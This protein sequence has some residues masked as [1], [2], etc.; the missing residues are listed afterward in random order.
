MKYGYLPGIRQVVYEAKFDLIV[1]D[2]IDFEYI[3]G[4]LKNIF[5]LKEEL[6]N[7]KYDEKKEVDL[8]L[9]ERMILL[10]N[11]IQSSSGIPS[12]DLGRIISH[13][14]V[15]LKDN[16]YHLIFSVYIPRLTH[17]NIE[18][19]L[20]I[21]QMSSKIFQFMFLK[22]IKSLYS[23]LD[24]VSK[25]IVLRFR[26]IYKQ[27][28]TM[29]PLL[30]QA[31][32]EDIPF[33]RIT[34][35]V[36]QLGLGSKSKL[37][38]RSMHD[39][40]SS[41]GTRISAN[42]LLT[43]DAF[44]QAGFP[45]LTA[46]YI[47]DKEDLIKKAEKLKW[48]VVVKPIDCGRSEGVTVDIRN[49]KLLL[50]AYSY[51]KKFS[52][53][54]MIEKYT[55][56]DV[57]RIGLI[58]N[59]LFLVSRRLPKGIVGDSSKKIKELI[60]EANEIENKKAPW[61]RFKPFPNDEEALRCIKKQGYTFD[62]IIKKDEFVF[63]REIPSNVHG[64]NAEDWTDKIHPANI[65]LAKQISKFLRLDSIGI[66]MISSSIDK[67][68]YEN[69]AK[70]LEV[71]ATPALGNSA[72]PWGNRRLKEFLSNC[73]PLGTRIPVNVYVGG[74]KALSKAMNKLK[75]LNQNGKSAYLVNHHSIYNLDGK[76]V[77]LCVENFFHRCQSLFMNINVEYLIVVIQTDE[78]LEIG[79]PFDKIS[80]L[81]IVDDNLISCK[82][83]KK[84]TKKRIKELKNI[85]SYF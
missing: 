7:L 2:N 47:K 31:F 38:F 25:S 8:S 82:T 55:K 21:Y 63:L 65:E 15:L 79:F 78:F 19:R 70:I 32:H 76:E 74:K 71:N 48:P 36:F 57:Y 17:V 73:F 6:V 54:I 72:I 50:A 49:E 80:E 20:N 40:D 43:Y 64:G 1:V 9:I 68:W 39:S 27:A 5:C 59:D 60:N 44:K 13:Q 62:S 28:D 85:L 3:D 33:F 16:K 77:F 56:G 10:S 29:I 42:K 18:H 12:F 14:K 51:A 11:L 4:L 46:S 23:F 58:N 67:P 61:L 41:I 24:Q 83:K 75:E 34:S 35:Q 52:K 30:E 53:D 84:L 26:A 69:D 66:D 37:F 81:E 45:I 22:D